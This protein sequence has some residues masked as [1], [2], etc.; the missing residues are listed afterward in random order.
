MV[1]RTVAVWVALATGILLLAAGRGLADPNNPQNYGPAEYQDIYN[2]C[3]PLLATVRRK[4]IE[5]QRIPASDEDLPSMSVAGKTFNFRYWSLAELGPVRQS[6][7][8]PR[9]APGFYYEYDICAIDRRIWQ[10]SNPGAVTGSAPPARTAAP[11]AAS[12]PP[13]RAP[14]GERSAPILT[15]PVPALALPGLPEPGSA[16]ASPV[17]PFTAAAAEGEAALGEATAEYDRTV[18]A[19]KPWET[20]QL[21][22]GEDASRCL[23][24][25]YPIDPRAAV[26]LIN[27]CPYR[28]EGVWCVVGHDCRPSYTNM[29]TFEPDA[30]YPIYG[31]EGGHSGRMIK[32]AA[33]RG[34]NTIHGGAGF[35]HQCSGELSP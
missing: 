34:R 10:L 2:H 21:T 5:G 25:V 15:T 35:L 28:I 33:C 17:Y 19:G 6:Y 24:P 14:Q 13:A 23:S 9:N 8:D 31:T 11:A 18:A 16:N 20:P 1:V 12:A 29:H 27:N 7:A 30:T 26:R 32:W 3:Q 4:L 22:E